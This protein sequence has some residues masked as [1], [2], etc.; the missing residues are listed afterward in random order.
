VKEVVMRGWMVVAI[1]L[2]VATVVVAEEEEKKPVGV[3]DDAPAVVLLDQE[4]KKV[5]SASYAGRRA[6]VLAFYPKDFT[7]G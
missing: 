4:G 2:A 6:V 7:G 3:G 5:E 1:G